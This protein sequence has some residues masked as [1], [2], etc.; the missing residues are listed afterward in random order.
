VIISG[1][2]RG[3][4]FPRFYEPDLTQR[5]AN[6]HAELAH[7]MNDLQ[8]AL[9][10]VRTVSDTAPRRAHA[11]SRRA[12]CTRAPGRGHDMLKR[13]QIFAFDAGRIMSRLCALSAIFAASASLDAEQ[14][15][16]LHLFAAPML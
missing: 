1:D 5:D 14:A 7:F 16:T 8:D 2:S 13:Q 10:F 3:F 12:L 6:F 4:E 15:T 11:K 9:E